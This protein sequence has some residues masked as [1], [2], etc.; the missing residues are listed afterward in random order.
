MPLDWSDF[1]LTRAWPLLICLGE[2]PVQPIGLDCLVGGGAKT[3][4]AGSN[5]PA[6]HAPGAD[7][8]LFQAALG[9]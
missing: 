5:T 2:V 8:L 9:V 3:A 1:R 7:L 6:I 4:A